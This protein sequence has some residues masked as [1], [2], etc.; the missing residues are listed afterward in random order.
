MLSEGGKLW[1]F[2]K[3]T[4]E[5]VNLLANPRT[6]VAPIRRAGI[7]LFIVPVPP[8]IRLG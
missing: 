2:A 8:S 3:E 7:R 1:P 5:G 4:A 6:V